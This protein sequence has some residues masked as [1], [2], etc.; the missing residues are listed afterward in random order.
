MASTY[1]DRLKLELMETGAN[2][3][4][5]GNNT[6]TNLQTV[7]AFTA[8]FLSKSIAGS[9]NVTLTTNN[10]DPT[11]ESSNKVI[12]L[13]GTLTGNVHV[14]IPAVENNYVIYNNTSGSFTVTIAAT[15]HAANGVEITQGSYSY[16]YCDGASNYNV[17]NIFSDLA[18]EDVTLSGNLTV[19]GNSTITGTST[20]TGDVTASGNV[21]V[22]TDVSTSGNLTVTGTSTLTGDVT[23]SGNLSVTGTSTLTGDLIVDTDT[24]F[25]DAANNAVGIGK[26]DPSSPLDV[27]GNVSVT[28]NISATADISAATFT[29][30]GAALTGISSTF[31]SELLHVRDEKGSTTA[32]GS[33]VGA[34]DNVRDL[35]TVVTNEIANASLSSNQVTLPAGTFYIEA[36][37]PCFNAGTFRAFLYNQSDS[38]VVILGTSGSTP[39]GYAGT[40]YSFVTG[41]FTIASSK[42]FEIRQYVQLSTPTNGLG[43]SVGDGRTNVYTDVQIWKI[44]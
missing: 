26:T 12:D 35:N 1:S 28:G 13:N 29:G 27:D 5:W 32:G 42:T 40:Y 33:S 37:A 6:N 11:A 43:A 41:R 7:D 31:D 22:S 3:N 15:G 19:T 39:S 23:A 36:K 10:A 25:V 44:T 2:A 20:L 21:N 38:S 9:S 30:N 14:F 4:T 24:L 17:K 34:S 16:L 8:G 18:L